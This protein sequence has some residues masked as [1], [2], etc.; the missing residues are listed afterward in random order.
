M[1]DPH[2]PC[3]QKDSP[4]R[5]TRCVSEALTFPTYPN[6]SVEGHIWVC[7]ESKAGASKA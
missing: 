2:T 7:L 1:G 5:C 4:V 6:V 3:L